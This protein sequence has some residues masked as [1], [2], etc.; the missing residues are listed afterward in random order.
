MTA[1]LRGVSELYGKALSKP[2]VLRGE[3]LSVQRLRGVAVLMVLVFHLEDVA[4]KLPG[5]A[6][7]HSAYARYLGYSAPDLFFVISGFI[8]TYITFSMPFEPRRWLISR[9]IRIVP[10]YLF[11]SSLVLL[12][13]LH[14]PSMTMGSGEHD[15]AS[16]SRSLLMLPQAGLPL[17]F[18]GWTIE[19]ELVFYALVFLVARFL[20][21]G[22]L[23]GVLLSLTLLAFGKWL[24]RQR[25]GLDFWDFHLLSLY[26]AQFALG[27]CI[28]RY[29]LKAGSDG[30]I[31]PALSGGLLLLA[32][33][34][35][36]ES[37]QI[38]REL[39]L[40]VLTFGGAYGLFLLALLNREKRLRALGRM[41]V[42]RDCLVQAGDAS[43]SIYLSH[44][45]V[46][47]ACG[48]LFPHLELA[49][50]LAWAAVMLAGALALAVGL[51]THLLLEKPI[52]ELG[53]RVAHGHREVSR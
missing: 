28:C 24:L 27:A 41:P 38:N 34:S 33:A 7:V 15:W 16:V 18:V 20:T 47:A 2:L 32:G 3:L 19:H 45:F 42:K 30:W 5:W 39:P 52:I 37:G 23:I 36:A 14:Q 13:W 11:F 22:W 4:R 46:L 17:L 26:I 1:I 9:F 48:K 31:L 8:M 12:L 49:P 10:M 35:F 25:T 40:R 43:Y 50:P 21:P 51:A 29:W 53:K 44:P 6:D